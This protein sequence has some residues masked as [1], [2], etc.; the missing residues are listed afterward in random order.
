MNGL[1]RVRKRLLESSKTKLLSKQFAKFKF[2]I[3]F[4][5]TKKFAEKCLDA[6][7]L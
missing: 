2:Q 4:D 5:F 6:S 7:S 1:E 3:G